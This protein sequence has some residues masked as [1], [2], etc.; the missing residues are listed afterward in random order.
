MFDKRP[1]L[2]NQDLNARNVNDQKRQAHPTKAVGFHSSSLFEPK[3]QVTSQFNFD[4]LHAKAPEYCSEFAFDIFRYLKNQ[5]KVYQLPSYVNGGTS[6]QEDHRAMIVDWVSEC[7]DVFQFKNETFYIAVRLFDAYLA[8]H[9][10]TPFSHLQ[11]IACT[12]LMIA[13]KY[14]EYSPPNMA[15]LVEIGQHSYTKRDILLAEIQILRSAKYK[16]GFPLA[17][18]FLRR[19]GQVF[20]LGMETMTLARFY[21]ELSQH[22]T[23]FAIVESPSKMAAAVLVLAI[24]GKKL[25]YDWVERLEYYSEHK[26][27]DIEVLAN[28]VGNAIMRFK[29]VFPKCNNTIQKYSGPELYEVS[30][31]VF[32]AHKIY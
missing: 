15:D 1:L 6:I 24:S 25:V 17:Y 31:G 13:S 27:G 12:S 2:R 32:G 19:Y 21:L 3:Q 16:L 29:E 7:V 22:F 30:L 14:E 11:L 4:A 5:E 10:K 18:S 8:A 26:V 20:G 28:R 9:P 23:E